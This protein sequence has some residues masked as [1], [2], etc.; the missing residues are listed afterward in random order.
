MLCGVEGNLNHPSTTAAPL[1]STPGT[2]FASPPQRLAAPGAEG[3]PRSPTEPS[4]GDRTAMEAV[5]AHHRP[6]EPGLR[7]TGLTDRHQLAT[8]I[9]PIDTLGEVKALQ[10]RGAF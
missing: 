9:I 10:S 4:Q 5:G 8:G 7:A 1:R 3:V 2:A 6:Q